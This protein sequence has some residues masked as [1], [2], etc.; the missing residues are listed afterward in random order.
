MVPNSL[1]V[2]HCAFADNPDSV[3]VLTILNPFNDAPAPPIGEK[4]AERAFMLTNHPEPPSFVY[5]AKGRCYSLSVGDVVAACDAE[6]EVEFYLCCSFGWSLLACGEEEGLK[7]Y[8]ALNA[9]WAEKIAKEGP[10][11]RPV[12]FWSDL[13]HVRSVD[14]AAA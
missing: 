13:A 14:A 4:W 5:E 8:A 11:A 9:K 12:R 7:E 6:G 1:Q 3:G 2:Y 10:L